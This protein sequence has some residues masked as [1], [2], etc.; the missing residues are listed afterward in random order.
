MDD[1]RPEGGAGVSVYLRVD[2]IQ[3]MYPE[4]TAARIRY[5]AMRDKW[6]RKRM[7][8][9]VGYDLASITDTLGALDETVV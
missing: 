5:L 7:G 2:E 4:L 3:V 9:F 1:A 8:K 6:E